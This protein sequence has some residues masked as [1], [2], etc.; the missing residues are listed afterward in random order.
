MTA[1]L[2]ALP[3]RPQRAPSSA[4]AATLWQERRGWVGLAARAL[5]QAG[6]RELAVRL[7]MSLDAYKQA[8]D[9]LAAMG[10]HAR[11]ADCCAAAAAHL[12]ARGEARM[13]LPWLAERVRRYRVM[14]QY[15]RAFEELQ[16]EPEVV[17]VGGWRCCNSARYAYYKVA[18]VC[19]DCTAP[20]VGRRR[21]LC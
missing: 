3:A 13:A 5:Q 2:L 6:E 7:Y 12:R 8:R 17:Q 9:L 1:P 18:N 14:N 15:G 11:L 16:R 4:A 20:C 10:D 21:W 19:S